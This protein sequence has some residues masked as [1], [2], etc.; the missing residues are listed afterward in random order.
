MRTRQQHEPQAMGL[1][2]S[3]PMAAESEEGRQTARVW[4]RAAG[5]PPQEVRGVVSR[6]QGFGEGGGA[7]PAAAAAATAESET[8]MFVPPEQ[9]D[10]LVAQALASAQQEAPH[11]LRW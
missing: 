9:I 10:T 2:L 11:S 6:G 3:S 5:P 4:R 1:V 7:E 8:G